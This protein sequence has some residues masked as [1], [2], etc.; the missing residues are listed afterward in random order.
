MS[1]LQHPRYTTP[2]SSTTRF[3]TRAQRVTDNK[4]ITFALHCTDRKLII[5]ADEN[6]DIILSQ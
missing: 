3:C 4:Y 6:M 5:D 1:T 2:S